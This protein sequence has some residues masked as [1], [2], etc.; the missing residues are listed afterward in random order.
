MPS[1]SDR[2]FYA[3]EYDNK[4]YILESTVRFANVAKALG[5]TE[6]NAVNGIIPYNSGIIITREL[7]LSLGVLVPMVINYRNISDT[8]KRG[9]V[10]VGIPI[11]KVQHLSATRY[12]AYGDGFVITSIKFPERY[13]FA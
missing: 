10:K 2:R 11:N 6:V 1:I 5:M 12:V 7:G 3:F 13:R 8:K 9:R 4:N